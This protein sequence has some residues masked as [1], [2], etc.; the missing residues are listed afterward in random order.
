MLL[1]KARLRHC[2][3]PRLIRVIRQLLL[4]SLVPKLPARA[5]NLPISSLSIIRHITL[6]KT[7]S[8]PLLHLT[9]DKTSEGLPNTLKAGGLLVTPLQVYET[10]SRKDFTEDLE[11][12]VGG[13]D[14]GWRD[15]NIDRVHSFSDFPRTIYAEDSPHVWA[16]FF[17]P[18]AAKSTIPILQRYLTLPFLSPAIPSP[19][20][21]LNLPIARIAAIGPTTATFLREK[22]T[23]PLGVD[24]VPVKPEAEA[25]AEAIGIADMDKSLGG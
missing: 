22:Y 6:A 13:L 18:S 1:V 14:R 17:A 20:T 24:V 7:V 4:L 2:S 16:V 15:V 5:R 23:P 19:S 8:P 12:I 21:S 25:L 10:W 9:G 11:R 3:L